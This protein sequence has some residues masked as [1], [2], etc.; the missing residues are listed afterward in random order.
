MDITR[1]IFP[2]RM[3][4]KMGNAIRQTDKLQEIR[5]RVNTP[6]MLR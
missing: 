5:I 2:G 3:Q 6:I 4:N 1:E